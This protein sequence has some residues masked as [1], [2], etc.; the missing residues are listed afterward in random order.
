[1]DKL[2]AHLSVNDRCV[3]GI[4]E[5]GDEIKH[6]RHIKI[7][8]DEWRKDERELLDFI[9]SDCEGSGESVNDLAT[10]LASGQITL[11]EFNCRIKAAV[12]QKEKEINGVKLVKL[13]S[14]YYTP[15]L[16]SKTGKL[17]Y[18]KHIVDVE[19][20][21][22]FVDNLIRFVAKKGTFNTDWMFSK[23][24]QT[25]DDRGVAMPYFSTKDNKYHDFYPDFVFWQ[26]NGDRYTITY[27]DPKGT[28]YASYLSKVDSFEDLFL[29]GGRPR[30]FE[31]M[32]YKI[33]FSL[34]LAY[35]GEGTIPRKYSSYWLDNNDFSWL[36]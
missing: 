14:H 34:K 35:D 1:M 16:I 20:E 24:D 28:E 27:V 11:D 2:I 3:A 36:D 5:L 6:F 9:D 31:Y 30:V 15:M 23:I 33:T 21:I 7:A 17:D 8:K 12:P 32:N 26:K 4:R 18:I 22:A 13:S 19:S 10:L 29:E 25:I